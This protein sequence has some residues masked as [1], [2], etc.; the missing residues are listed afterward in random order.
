M[1]A[2]NLVIVESPAKAKTISRFLGSDFEVTASMGHVRDLPKSK[3]SIDVENDFEPTYEVSS[4]KKKVIS[5][6]KKMMDKDTELWIATDEDREGE[7]IGWHL[8]EALKIPAGKRADVKR[9]VFHEI[10]ESAI[11]DAIMRPRTIDAHLVDAQQA[12]R[13]LDRLV[14]YELS[15]LLWKKVRYGLSAGRVQSV[16]VRFVVEREREIRAFDAQEYWS[17]GG[18]FERGENAFEA[19]LSKKSGVKISIGNEMEAN[20][21]LDELKAV[22]GW[23]VA[24]VETKEQK[25]NPAP[26]FITSTLQQ[27]AARKLG[28]SVKQTM[29]IAQ[30]LYEG[31]ALPEGHVGL[32][33][34]MRT[35]SVNLAQSALVEAQQVIA[36]TFGKEYALEQPRFYKSKKGAQEAHEAIRPTALGRAPEDVKSHLDAKQ[37]KLYDLIWK[38]TMACQMAEARVEQIG[39]D[40]EGGEYDAICGAP[41]LIK[42]YRPRI[43]MEVWGGEI[44]RKYSDKAVKKLQELGYKAFSLES[45][46]SVSKEPIDDP[47][48][49]I[50]DSS[51]GARDN[52]LFSPQ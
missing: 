15:P 13:V 48:G 23:K 42:K 43:I 46:G 39:V 5:G 38:R 17:I 34:Y 12:R 27:E 50:S 28:F 14:G 51:H 41:N 22:S 3:M 44:G 21:I 47:V 36:Q 30:Q 10:T 37:F 18:R 49:S 4:D 33:T 19:E 40:I 1:A 24:N 8:L 20:G 31:I 29:M 2:K 11:K 16:A 45:E 35:D 6:L 32:I 7:A 26:P 25:R 52:F 9:I